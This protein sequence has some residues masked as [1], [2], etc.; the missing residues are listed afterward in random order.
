MLI[1]FLLFLLSRC[2]LFLLSKCFLLFLLSRCVLLFLLFLLSGCF[3][4]C[5]LGFFGFFD[6]EL[7]QFGIEVFGIARDN[8]QIDA[9]SRLYRSLCRRLGRRRRRCRRAA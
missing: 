8:G 5:F 7:Q 1:C 2:F 9:R 3:L 4:F 6:E